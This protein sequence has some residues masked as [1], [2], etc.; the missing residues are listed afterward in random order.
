MATKFILTDPCL[1][2]CE[3]YDRVARIH[4]WT[5][6]GLSDVSRDHPLAELRAAEK[7]CQRDYPR[8]SYALCCERAWRE[9]QQQMR[10][11]RRC[12]QWNENS[13]ET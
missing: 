3:R 9:T 10:E 4:G 6:V 7:R 12:W 1:T 5:P 11:V 13:G 8:L 2:P